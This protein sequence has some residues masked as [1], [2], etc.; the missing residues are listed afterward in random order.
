MTVQTFNPT[1]LPQSATNWTVAQRSVAAFAPH[2]QNAPD[3][4]LVLDQGH[5]LLGTTL[6]EVATQLV[7]PF[8]PPASGFRIDRVVVNRTT[9]AAS[10]A[11]G[12]VNSLTPPAIPAGTLPI[13]RVM[14]TSGLT[15]ITNDVIVDERALSDL[16]GP[17]A[18]VVFRANLNGV[19]QSVP[20]SVWTK[21]QLSSASFDTDG[22]FDAANN[23]Y[24]PSIAGYYMITGN[25]AIEIPSPGT[26]Y[27][28]GI[29]KN[30][31]LISLVHSTSS[32]AALQASNVSDIAYLDGQTDYVDLCAYQSNGAAALVNG[33]VHQTYFAAQLI[34]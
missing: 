28:T 2:A 7:G 5:L 15:A 20:S 19:N 9:G 24:R 23:R 18:P 14:L 25:V 6:T 17:P 12:T 13:A 26:R 29:R 27:G 33:L 31:I 3:L 32:A 8:A 30:G 21:V 22:G 4:S 1:A 10:V 11:A 16:A 34:R